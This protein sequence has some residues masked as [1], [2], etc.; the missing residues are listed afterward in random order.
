MK[1]T[2]VS[3]LTQEQQRERLELIIEAARVGMWDWNPQTNA[4]VFSKIW[5]EMIGYDVD[6]ISP[7]FRGWE[8]RIHPDDIE[9][10]HAD[11]QAHVE[12]KTVFYENVHRLKHRDGHWVHILARG[13]IVE[14]DEDGRPVRFTGTHTDI[15]SQKESELAALHAANAKSLFLANMSHE[16][17]TPLNGI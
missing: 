17:R 5:T 14:R 13:W 8:S 12:G 6:E 1:K 7:A 4:V 2:N 9:G 3:E 10:C 11:I 15:T 16:I